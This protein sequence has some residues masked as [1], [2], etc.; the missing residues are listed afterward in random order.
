MR[1]TEKDTRGKE[2]AST[3]NHALLEPKHH[4]KSIQT[5]FTPTRKASQATLLSQASLGGCVGLCL[6]INQLLTELSTGQCAYSIYWQAL[7]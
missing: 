6:L 7:T 3:A 2:N 5:D 1:S 4:E